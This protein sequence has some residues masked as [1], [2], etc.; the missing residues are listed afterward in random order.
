MLCE[1]EYIVKAF[2]LNDEKH[3][4]LRLGEENFPRSHSL[5]AKRNLLYLNVYSAAALVSYLA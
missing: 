1:G 3:A 5:L 4:L 2:L